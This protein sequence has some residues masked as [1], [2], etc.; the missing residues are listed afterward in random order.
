[1]SVDFWGRMSTITG[2]CV[3]KKKK[4]RKTVASCLETW[5]KH[6]WCPTVRS[7]PHP[8]GPF[9]RDAIKKQPGFITCDDVTKAFGSVVLV[10]F[11]SVFK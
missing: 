9:I 2:P 3:L 11:T 4:K 7:H 5:T 6:N 8:I 10:G 1:M